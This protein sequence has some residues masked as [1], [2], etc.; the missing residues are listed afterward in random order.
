MM[1]ECAGLTHVD[2]DGKAK[3]RVYCDFSEGG[4]D[5][6]VM[7]ADM[8]LDGGEIR[9]T[10]GSGK[11]KGATGSGTMKRT[12]ETEGTGTYTYKFDITTP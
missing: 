1:G 12:G 2:P 5:R 11:W 10:G 3:S 7:E 8:G 4:E 6:F 9:I